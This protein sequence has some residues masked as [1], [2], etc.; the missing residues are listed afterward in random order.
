MNSILIL[1]II[2]ATISFRLLSER[3]E[4]W[5]RGAIAGFSVALKKDMRRKCKNRQAYNKQD[6]DDASHWRGS[7]GDSG[8]RF[9]LDFFFSGRIVPLDF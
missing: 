8:D 4:Y 5:I 6:N 3:T 1:R 2:C 9:T 7:P